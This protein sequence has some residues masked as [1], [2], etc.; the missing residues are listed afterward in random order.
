MAAAMRRALLVGRAGMRRVGAVATS[1]NFASRTVVCSVGTA[2]APHSTAVKAASSRSTRSG[3]AAGVA[4]LATV[5]S[6]IAGVAALDEGTSK[7]DGGP[8]MA[9]DGHNK[10]P[11]RPDLPVYT[12]EQ[13]KEN[14]SAEFG[15]KRLWVTFRGGVYDVTDFIPGTTPRA[16]RVFRHFCHH[17]VPCALTLLLTGL[18]V[19]RLC[20][21]RPPRAF[22]APQDGRRHG[23]GA[24]L[25]SVPHG[26]R[27]GW[28]RGCL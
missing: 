27:G 8:P 22:I 23:S 4:A 7:P 20:A 18:H 3:T 9:L 1:R 26:T 11:P 28:P 10:V 5:A 13:V 16:A 17:L 14:Y 19:S 25:E 21:G 2:P 12:L 6:L 15:T 24:V